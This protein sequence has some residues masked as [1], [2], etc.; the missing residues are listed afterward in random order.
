MQCVGQTTDK[1]H[2]WCNNYKACYCRS[3][4]GAEVAQKHLNE[5]FTGEN[6]Q[7]LEKNM[8]KLHQ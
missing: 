7:G 6:H 4:R 5:H 2:Y 1:F 8:L 3:C